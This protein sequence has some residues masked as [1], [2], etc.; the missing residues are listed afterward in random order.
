[1]PVPEPKA[2]AVREM[3]QAPFPPG[4]DCRRDRLFSFLPCRHVLPI[5]LRQPPCGRNAAASFRSIPDSEANSP[6][7]T[8][9]LLGVSPF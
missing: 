7:W 8:F 4:L 3:R 9:S 5:F 6:S 1:M 2:E